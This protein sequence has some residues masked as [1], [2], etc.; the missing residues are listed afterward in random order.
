MKKFDKI[1]ES[2]MNECKIQIGSFYDDTQ[3][4][5]IEIIGKNED[6][7]EIVISDDNLIELGGEATEVQD[8]K[9]I[10]DETLEFDGVKFDITGITVADGDG[11]IKTIDI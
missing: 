8:Y 2:V 11:E 1:Y 3:N 9:I 10:D 7:K 6:G 4:T 5:V